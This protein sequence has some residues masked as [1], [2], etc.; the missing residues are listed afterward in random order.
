MSLSAIVLLVENTAKSTF[1]FR[2]KFTLPIDSLNAPT[3][4]K[5]N[6]AS[7]SRFTPTK[8]STPTPAPM[9]IFGEI[10][11]IPRHK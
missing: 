8:P 4:L 11:T 10:S 6:L 7:A 2:L 9:P 3:T 5:L 1:T